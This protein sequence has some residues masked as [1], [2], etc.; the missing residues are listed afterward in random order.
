MRL[1]MMKMGRDEDDEEEGEWD[2][3]ELEEG[4]EEEDDEEEEGEGDEEEGEGEEE[5]LEEGEGD[6]EEGEGDEEEGEGSGSL[7]S[8]GR[9]D[10]AQQQ[11]HRGHT[12]TSCSSSGR[13]MDPGA[14]PAPPRSQRVRFELRSVLMKMK[15]KPL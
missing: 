3:E 8:S 9:G 14:R 2:E 13:G 12:P 11:L 15:M 4:D 10:S 5:E 7:R 1:K 6:E